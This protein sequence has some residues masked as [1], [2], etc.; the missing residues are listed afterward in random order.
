M[1]GLSGLWPGGPAVTPWHG[2]QKLP[3]HKLCKHC[4]L[5]LTNT[6]RPWGTPSRVIAAVGHSCMATDSSTEGIATYTKAAPPSRGVRGEELQD[7]Y[8]AVKG[9]FHD[10]VSSSCTSGKNGTWVGRWEPVGPPPR[11]HSSSLEGSGCGG[12]FHKS[13]TFSVARESI[14]VISGSGSDNAITPDG[15]TQPGCHPRIERALRCRHLIDIWSSGGAPKNVTRSVEV[16]AC[17]N[18]NLTGC[19][20][21]DG[22]GTPRDP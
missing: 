21:L 17:S 20:A 14:D 1:Q 18:S 11:N 8:R 19:G 22:W 13:P 16:P 12:G 2:G 9:A 6:Y 4:Q 3:P 10:L 7:L 5:G 15:A